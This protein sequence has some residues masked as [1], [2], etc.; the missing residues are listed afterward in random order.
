MFFR[1]LFSVFLFYLAIFSPGIFFILLGA[2]A[3]ILFENFYEF[4]IFS[5]I[6]DILYGFPVDGFYGF[7]FVFFLASAII[8]LIGKV[9]RKKVRIL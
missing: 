6:I 2:A 1:I 5:L 7:R 4:L 9:V 8:F 3:V